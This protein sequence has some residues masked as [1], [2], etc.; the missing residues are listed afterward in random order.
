MKNPHSNQ[1][2]KILRLNKH[3]LFLTI[4]FLFMGTFNNLHAQD[5]P[6]EITKYTFI[7]Y[8]KNQIEIQND[9]LAYN[10]LFKQFTN[11]GLKGKGKINIVHIGDSHIQAD[12]LSG[13]FRKKLQSFF[14]GSISG[15]GF[16]F[17]YKVA[18]TN[19]P[20]NYQ[21]RSTGEWESCRNVE[22]N[23]KCKLGLSG[24][25]VITNDTLASIKI[26]IDDKKL[27]GYDFDR[28]MV[29]HD[30]GPSC[31]KPTI[32][33]PYAKNIIT[34]N[35]LGYTLFEFSESANSVVFTV[36]KTDSLQNH[37]TLHGINFDSSDAGITYHT[38]GV[39]GAQV[40][41]YLKCDYFIPHLQALNPNWIIV[42]LGTND[43]YTNNFDSIE[44]ALNLDS[45]ID[46]LKIAAPNSA[47][48]LSTP[49]DHKIKRSD[50]NTNTKT[51]S[52]IIRQKAFEHKLSYWDFNTIMGGE[53]SIDAWRA[54][55][56][57]HTDF[58][59]Y[60]KKGYQYQGQLLFN[61]FLK[62][63]DEYLEK[64]HN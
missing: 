13:T 51:A 35:T 43:V 59:H 40:D 15:R 25:A 57:A 11:I 6:Y 19:N 16:I 4:G 9:S 49:G 20:F 42:S 5:N 50:I 8:E 54:T 62:A 17:P 10:Q 29:F 1:L 22:Q 38:V 58:L 23:L 52:K 30:F 55:E 37:F 36:N 44:F 24:I 63:Y 48:L 2:K 32:S 41:S 45:F 21:V 14:L 61:A 27:A 60:T 46:D 26:S 18:K 28:L 7:N 56:M 47:I 33:Y 34:N 64:T 3:I 39:N 31:Y 12:F 53:G